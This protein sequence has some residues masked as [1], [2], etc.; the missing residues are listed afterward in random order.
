MAFDS[1][2]LN[3]Q[4]AHLQSEVMEPESQGCLEFWY[5]MDMWFIGEHLCREL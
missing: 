1:G 4:I 2:A 3:D 5:H